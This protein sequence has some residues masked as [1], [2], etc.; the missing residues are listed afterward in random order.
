VRG[1]LVAEGLKIKPSFLLRRG[2]RSSPILA[3]RSVL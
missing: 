2:G 1:L 3:I